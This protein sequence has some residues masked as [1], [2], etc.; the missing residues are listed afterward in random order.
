ML[1]TSLRARHT[2]RWPLGR[3]A[4]AAAIA[5][6]VATCMNSS[7]PAPVDLTYVPH[8]WVAAG[9]EFTLGQFD[10]ATAWILPPPISSTAVTYLKT[11]PGPSYYN[12]APPTR[13]FYFK[14]TSLGRAVITLQAVLGTDS[15]SSPPFVDTVD[16]H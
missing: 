2:G 6:S 11:A 4:I 3:G 7:A 15:V 12:P 1:T 10:L 5:L 16:V 9:T 13:L 8:A 14:A